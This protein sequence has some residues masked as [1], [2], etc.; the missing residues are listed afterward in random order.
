MTMTVYKQ[1]YPIRVQDLPAVAWNAGDVIALGG[2]P[3]VAD[4]DNP[5]SSSG[6]SVGQGSLSVAL[7]VYVG[8][9]D[10]AYPVGMFVYWSVPN[11]QF[12]AVPGPGCVPFG[13]IVFGPAGLASDGGPTGAGSLCGVFHLPQPEMRFGSAVPAAGQFCSFGDEGNLY[14]N[15]GNPIA[16][17]AADTTDDILGGFVLAPNCFDGIGNRGLCIT[18]SG[19]TGATTNNKRA[20]LWLNPTMAGQAVTNGVISGGTVSGV[21][22]GVL[23][24]DTGAWVN[25]TTPNNAA[26]W[27]I[28]VNLFKYGAAGS[29]TQYS[30]AQVIT[31]TLHGGITPP[32]FPTQTEGSA[33]NFVVTGSSYT[34]GAANDVMLN[35]LEANAM[36]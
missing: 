29:N 18:A 17:N 25:G 3:A 32:L 9:A 19:K 5:P 21:G 36:N 31:G 35:F 4:M 23:L 22:T 27:Q 1:G 7:G 8:P 11:S 28:L 34:T 33:W 16:G 2:V 15:V 10:A 12:T 24:A 13:F 26:G 30:Q 6:L 20:K 14:R